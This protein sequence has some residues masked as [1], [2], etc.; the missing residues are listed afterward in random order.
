MSILSME[1]ILN[2]TCPVCSA[3]P[4]AKCLEKKVGG[5]GGMNWIE[6]PHPERIRKA[7]LKKHELEEK[8]SKE[9]K[10]KKKEAA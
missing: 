10:E 7:L 4:T 6:N 1:E 2:S 8:E 3:A 9:T 5:M